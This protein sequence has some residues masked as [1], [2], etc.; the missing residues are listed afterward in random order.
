MGDKELSPAPSWFSQA[1]ACSPMRSSFTVAGASI[2]LL[3]WGDLGKPGLLFLHGGAAHADWWR[4]IAPF[5]AEHWR[6]AAISWSGMGRSDWR[7][8][9]SY[10]AFADEILG[11][12]DAAGLDRGGAAPVLV[13]HS[14][15]GMPALHAALHHSQEVRGLVLLDC[16]LRMRA[17]SGEARPVRLY[18]SLEDI[19]ARF[20]FVPA[21]LGPHPYIR[22]FIARCSVK[23]VRTPDGGEGWTWL[24]DPERRLKTQQSD[25]GAALADLTVPAFFIAGALSTIVTA[26]MRETMRQVAPRVRQVVLPD[27][28]HHL[29]VDQ[30]LALVAALRTILASWAL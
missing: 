23:S 28:G 27:A 2:E 19:L 6:V 1:L 13:A 9:Y 24:F 26:E 22:D 29:M 14:F 8:T 21:Q 30:P 10:A 17:A 16:R 12:I 7:E 4:F 5:F 25:P 3:T 11:A 18:P 15:G 20:R